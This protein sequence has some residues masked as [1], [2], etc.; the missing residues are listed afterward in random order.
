MHGY[1]EF[2]LLVTSL[3]APT[4][5]LIGMMLNRRPLLASVGLLTFVFLG[6]AVHML[7]VLAAPGSVI[8]P[9]AAIT[10]VLQFPVILIATFVG[11]GAAMLFGGYMK[12]RA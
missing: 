11:R 3:T 7:V 2:F 6:V 1:Y 4:A 5:L 9:V 8:A 12:W 10:A